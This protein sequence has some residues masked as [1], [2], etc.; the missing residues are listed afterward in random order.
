MTNQL[1]E[2][3]TITASLC[4]RRDCF[5]HF[6]INVR[7]LDIYGVKKETLRKITLKIHE[8]Q[9]KDNDLFKNNDIEDYWGYFSFEENKFIFIYQKYFLLNMCFPCGIEPMEDKQYGKA[10]RL[11][12]V[13]VDEYIDE[14]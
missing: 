11:E 10:Y 13:N 14:L 2:T 8:D 6:G 3:F 4:E 12:I 7:F 9:S 5:K 1:P